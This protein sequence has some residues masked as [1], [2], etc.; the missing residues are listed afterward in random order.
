MAISFTAGQDVEPADLNA[1]VTYYVNKGADETVTSSTSLQDD[2]HFAG[3][4]IPANTTWLAEIWLELAGGEVGDF[5]CAWAVTGTA[6]IVA[7]H[8]LGM[9]TGET[10]SSDG[11]V[12][13]QVRDPG[14][15]VSNMVDASSTTR[16]S[17]AEMLKLSGGASGGTLTFR[18][19]QDTS[20]GTGTTIK[21][22]SSWFQMRRVA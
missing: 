8:C 7:R 20:S 4:P 14:S 11:N 3:I 22:N 15:A 5:Q 18:W 1:L 12:G 17:T 21:A 9:P 19:S 16:T 2:N 6:T 13:I 10:N